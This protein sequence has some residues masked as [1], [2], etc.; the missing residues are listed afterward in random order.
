MNLCTNAYHAMEKTGGQLTVS[1]TN[2]E[3]LN[4]IQLKDKK[5]LPGKYVRLQVEDTGGGMGIQQ[6]VQKPVDGKE[7]IR[8]TRSF[9]IKN[10]PLLR[11]CPLFL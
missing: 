5:I 4:P 8:L 1:L 10:K 11:K 2:Q 9:L 3:I 7:L 6:L